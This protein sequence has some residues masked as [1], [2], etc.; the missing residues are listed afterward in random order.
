M[1]QGAGRVGYAMGIALLRIAIAA[2]GGYAMVRLGT[3]T[4]GVFAALAAGLAVYGI[5]N[6]VAVARGVWFR[7]RV[8]RSVQI[9]LQGAK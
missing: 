4:A 9:A 7:K 1:T 3:G 2:L 5:L 6:V 8:R